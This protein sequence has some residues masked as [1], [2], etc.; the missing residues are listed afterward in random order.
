MSYFDQVYQQLFD[1]KP[2]KSEVL[3]FEVIQRNKRF[4]SDYFQR[5]KTDEFRKLTSAIFSSYELKKNAID[6]TPMVHLLNSRNANGFAILY[7]DEMEKTDFQYFFD[8][9]SERTQTLNYQLKNSDVT[10]TEKNSVVNSRKTLSK[11]TS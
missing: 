9:L 5:V 1:E 6:K 8:W 7:H 4:K 2:E 10:F 3:V 11:T